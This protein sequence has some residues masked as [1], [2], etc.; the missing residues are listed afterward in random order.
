MTL[1]C[2][3]L[4]STGQST[5]IPYRDIGMALTLKF[6][7]D[8]EAL[9]K[10]LDAEKIIGEWKARPNGVHTMKR[11]N[12]AR[13]HWASTTGTLWCDG[14]TELASR[15]ASDVTMALHLIYLGHESA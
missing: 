7:G 5:L 3:G 13:L 2:P 6:H 4:M 10:L 14:K 12:G 8:L 9:H 15:L 11:A 1:N